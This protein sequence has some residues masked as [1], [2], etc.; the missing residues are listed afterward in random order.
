MIRSD[1]LIATISLDVILPRI[2]QQWLC[3]GDICDLA[4]ES[5]FVNARF[6][7]HQIYHL[8]TFALNK[9]HKRLAV[10]LI[11]RAFDVRPKDVRHALEKGDTIPRGRG[12]H[13]AFE[14]G[15]EQQL[16]D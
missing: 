8:Y 12:E 2:I 5:N 10:K 6:R 14:E 11:A 7:A 1:S 15:I 9:F 3:E 16:I 13:P 4:L